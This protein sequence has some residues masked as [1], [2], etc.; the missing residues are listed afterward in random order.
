MKNPASTTFISA[1][2]QSQFEA[3]IFISARLQS[4]FEAKTLRDKNKDLAI[5]NSLRLGSLF[6]VLDSYSLMSLFHETS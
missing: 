4:Q 1:M 6:E 5:N 2:L 3:K